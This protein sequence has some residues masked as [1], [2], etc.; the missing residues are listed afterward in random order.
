MCTCLSMR[1]NMVVCV[2]VFDSV[3]AFEREAGW[4]SLRVSVFFGNTCICERMCVK[5]SCIWGRGVGGIVTSF[6]VTLL[7]PCENLA[8]L[9][10]FSGL[11]LFCQSPLR[12]VM[13]SQDRS[14]W[15]LE[16]SV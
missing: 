13:C 2:L 11:T 4:E 7:V 10:L 12:F 9:R 8:V 3:C 14:R 1:D 5:H 15:R 16:S 6:S